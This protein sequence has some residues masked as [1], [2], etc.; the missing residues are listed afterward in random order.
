VPIFLIPSATERF[1]DCRDLDD[2]DLQSLRQQVYVVAN[3]LR[4]QKDAQISNTE[5]STLF[6]HS[7][8]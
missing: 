3:I 1:E 5:Q 6:G 4:N 2:M 8:G 7:G